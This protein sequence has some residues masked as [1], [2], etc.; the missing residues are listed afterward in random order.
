MK[1]S[2]DISSFL[3]KISGLSP[4]AVFLYFFALFIE[5]GLLVSPCCSL[6]LCI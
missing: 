2:F 3:K 5:E 1:Y 4:S 6:K